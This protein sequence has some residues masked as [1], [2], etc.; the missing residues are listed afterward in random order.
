MQKDGEKAHSAETSR[1]V[2]SAAKSF[3]GNGN[4]IKEILSGNVSEYISCR[5]TAF[6]LNIPAGIAFT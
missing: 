3:G 2:F 6:K 4:T 1:A 5:Q